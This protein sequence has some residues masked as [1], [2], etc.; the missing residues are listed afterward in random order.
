MRE[1]VA[2]D[3]LALAVGAEF[4]PIAADRLITIDKPRSAWIC[5]AVAVT[6]FVT[7]KTGNNVSSSTSRPV[8][9]SAKPPHPSAI[10][11]PFT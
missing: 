1:G 3:C 2:D 10:N 7:E 4:G 5:S 11:S 8:V 6:A 9:S